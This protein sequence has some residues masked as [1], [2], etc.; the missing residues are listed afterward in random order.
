MFQQFFAPQNV[1]AILSIPLSSRLPSDHLVWAY[2]PKGLFT[3]KTAYKLTMSLADMLQLA[4]H[5]PLRFTSFFRRQF[6]DSM[7]PMKKNHLLGGR[8][9]IF[10][11]P[12]TISVKDRL[13]TLLFV[14]PVEMQ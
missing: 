2:M 3:V 4:R 8:V 6:G 12:K 1:R 9:K 11:L 13:L 7:Y 10:C 5:L 14:K